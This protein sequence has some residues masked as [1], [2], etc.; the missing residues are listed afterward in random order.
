MR[1]VDLV[2]LNFLSFVPQDKTPPNNDQIVDITT[3]AS[4]S[5]PRFLLPRANLYLRDQRL[6]H[7]LAT[8]GLRHASTSAPSKP[9][10]L[11]KPERFNPPSHPARLRK[12]PRQYPGAPLAE[13]EREAQKTRQYPHMMPPEG[14]FMHWFLTNKMI[15]TWITLVRLNGTYTSVRIE[16]LI[17][18]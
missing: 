3:M 15:H 2:T 9:R 18:L 10:V 14:S 7:R 1:A 4:L 16:V 12:T 6:Q 17:L 11:E 8:L 13:H 5:I